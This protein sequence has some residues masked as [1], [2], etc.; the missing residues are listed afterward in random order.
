MEK[1]AVR[2]KN[3]TEAEIVLDLIPD[4]PHK[5]N[6]SAYDF[7]GGLDKVFKNGD[8]LMSYS[9]E[10]PGCHCDEP[11]YR[12]SGYKVLSFEEFQ[13]TYNKIKVG[14]W[15]VNLQEF[16]NKPEGSL[17]KVTDFNGRD[18]S[19]FFLEGL[20]CSWLKSRF[21]KATP[22]E[23]TNHL[24]NMKQ[25]I[26]YYEVIK[27]FPGVSVGEKYHPAFGSILLLGN[28]IDPTEYHEF[29]KP[30]YKKKQK[31]FT[32]QCSSGNFEVEIVHLSDFDKVA[33][34]DGKDWSVIALR[35]LVQPP[36]VNNTNNYAI[37][38]NVYSVSV[39]CKKG[40]TIQS[41]KDLIEEIDPLPF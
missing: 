17:F 22:A 28:A 41:L 38:Y 32:L 18:D 4:S 12:A 29:F 25:E 24:K 2:V 14:D 16:E 27:K 7:A 1:I 30:V 20:K 26:D 3:G 15:V 9:G 35:N 5:T 8:R 31:F 40:I 34:F 33:R 39:G 21:R 11:W 36:V 23:I 10:Y 19:D 37:S 6:K 13:E